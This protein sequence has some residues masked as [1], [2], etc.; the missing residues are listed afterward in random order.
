M[1]KTNT[2]L[3]LILIGFYTSFA[4]SIV[5]NG[6]TIYISDGSTLTFTQDYINLGN[7]EIQNNGQL[8]VLADWTNNGTNGAN[9][10][11]Y[12][13]F[14]N[15]KGSLPQ[16]ISGSTTTEF[17]NLQVEQ[18]VKMFSDITVW[19]ELELTGGKINIKNNDLD[20]QGWNGIVANSNYYVVAQE[21]GKLKMFVDMMTPA[22]FPVGTNTTYNPVTLALNS[23]SDTYM[24]NLA[25]DVLT[26]GS[27]GTTIPEINDCVNMTWNVDAAYSGWVNYNMTVQW[28]ALQEGSGFDRTHSAIG[29]YHSAQWNAN[30]NQAAN[31]GNPY[32][33]SQNNI[34]QVG[35]FAVG[36]TESPMAITLDLIVDVTALLEGPFDGIEMLTLLNDDGRLP[37]SQPYN[38]A[39]WNYAGT[40][41]VTTIPGSEIVDWVLVELRDAVNA[42]SALPTTVIERQAAFVMVDGTIVGMDGSSDLQ[43]TNSP[44]QN[45]FVVIYHRNHLSVMSAN[46]VTESGGVYTYNFTTGTNQAYADGQAGQKEIATGIWGMYGGDG[47]GGG[48][49]T[50][51]DN[52]NVWRPTVGTNG[53]LKADY[54]LDGQVENKDKNDVW[55]G[56]YMKSS[57][58]PE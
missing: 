49:I 53:Y 26:N 10:L 35:N 9:S 12:S 19:N 44:S 43:F 50:D 56:N 45:L 18:D 31:G 8:D 42:A 58:V 3:T 47:S 36:D 7:G 27:S 2:I 55:V 4:Q 30:A 1:K 37:L 57:Q 25:Q 34:G 40:E 5:N 52:Q 39:P 21:S 14:V 22:V 16:T 24:V 23:A 54:N 38:T 13:G 17:N 41:S 33:L 11:G 20:Y 48:N 15:F 28:D 6:S 51:Y 32:S 46:A 29:E